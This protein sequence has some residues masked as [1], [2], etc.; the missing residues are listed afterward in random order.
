[1]PGDDYYRQ[2]SAALEKPIGKSV[3]RILRMMP[4]EPPQGAFS[5]M[6]TMIGGRQPPNRCFIHK[7]NQLATYNMLREPSGLMV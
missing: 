6:I 5:A 1:M 3:D 7:I 4:A 2:H